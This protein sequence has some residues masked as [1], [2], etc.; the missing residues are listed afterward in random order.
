MYIIIAASF[1]KTTLVA[2]SQMI[3]ENQYAKSKILIYSVLAIVL[4][5]LPILSN[6]GSP[7]Q[8]TINSPMIDLLESS[9]KW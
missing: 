9:I 2:D 7:L 6:R 5:Q 4:S 8:I 3:I 1:D